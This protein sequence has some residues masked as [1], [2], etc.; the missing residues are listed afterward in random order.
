M[1]VNL[2]PPTLCT[3]LKIISQSIILYYYLLTEKKST[4]FHAW[5]LYYSIITY[6]SRLYERVC[7]CA[8]TADAANPIYCFPIEFRVG[9]HV[10]VYV[11][12]YYG[13]GK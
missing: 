10:Y 9:I 7:V 11:Y 13:G 1:F 2:L 4:N 5:V 6:I 8:H 12:I 3:N